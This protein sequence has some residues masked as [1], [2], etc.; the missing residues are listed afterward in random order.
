MSIVGKTY[1]VPV[2]TYI[3]NKTKHVNLKYTVDGVPAVTLSTRTV[4][5]INILEGC[6]IEA[7]RKN[8]V[9]KH[10]S[11]HTPLIVEWLD[12]M[13]PAEI[14]I[15]TDEDSLVF[16]DIVLSITPSHNGTSINFN[17]G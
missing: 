1:V 5:L 9:Y 14:T 4:E 17:F 11:S 3:E 2:Y 8:T 13:V 12:T 7:Y 15:L 10:R 6:V 16:S